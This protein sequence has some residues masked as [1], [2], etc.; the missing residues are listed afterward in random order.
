MTQVEDALNNYQSL[1]DYDRDGLLDLIYRRIERGDYE[2]LEVNNLILKLDDLVINGENPDIEYSYFMVLGL[3]ATLTTA[4]AVAIA[5]TT[6]R[7]DKLH[8]DSLYQALEIISESDKADKLIILSKFT[9]HK[10]ESIS[11]LANK[12]LNQNKHDR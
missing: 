7:L 4:Q 6:R 11:N 12:L 8:P 2:E 5:I 1:S 3:A 9:H 10:E